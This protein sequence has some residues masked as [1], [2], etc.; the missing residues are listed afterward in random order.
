CACGTRSRAG[1]G[2]STADRFPTRGGEETLVYGSAS[3]ARST[4]RPSRL[5][6]ALLPATGWR[7]MGASAASK[8]GLAAPR[9]VAPAAAAAGREAVVPRRL[10]SP[11]PS[12][13]FCLAIVPAPASAGIVGCAVLAAAFRARICP[14]FG[15][16]CE[17]L[18]PPP[19]ISVPVMVPHRW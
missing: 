8:E 13:P 2:A 19:A 1:G 11:A 3:C 4:R 14:V 5:A 12:A 16:V 10:R 6:L 9:G 15:L 18:M 17:L 7:S